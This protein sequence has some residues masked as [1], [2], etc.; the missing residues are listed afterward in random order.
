MTIEELK[1]SYPALCQ[2]IFARGFNAGVKCQFAS[3]RDDSEQRRLEAAELIAGAVQN[4]DPVNYA[5]VDGGNGQAY[6]V[7]TY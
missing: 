4:R 3:K 5:R 1:R 2:E 7:P 6:V